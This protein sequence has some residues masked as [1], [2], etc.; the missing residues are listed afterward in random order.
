MGVSLLVANII[1]PWNLRRHSVAAAPWN[2]S[3]KQ[4]V[5]K[6]S[7][8]EKSF[9]NTDNHSARGRVRC[10]GAAQP[11]QIRQDQA[12]G[13]VRRAWQPYSPHRHKIGD[14]PEILRLGTSVDFWL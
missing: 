3:C 13:T 14:G 1:F 12:G 7:D 8:H 9:G 5:Q 10:A 11:S 4:E 6:E 2:E